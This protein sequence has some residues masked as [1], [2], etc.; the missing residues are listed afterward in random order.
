MPPDSEAR[1]LEDL[2]DAWR[3]WERQGKPPYHLAQYSRAPGGQ[4]GVGGSE[5]RVTIKN[6]YGEANWK[7]DFDS[8]L[9]QKNKLFEEL[10]KPGG[11]IIKLREATTKALRSGPWLD[12]AEVAAPETGIYQ[13]QYWMYNRHTKDEV[14]KEILLTPPTV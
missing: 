5:E 14:C 9:K 2:M 8:L 3:G 4:N 11:S 10:S 1:R 12:E 13:D 6:G 7:F